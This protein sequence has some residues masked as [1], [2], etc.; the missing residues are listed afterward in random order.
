MV[1]KI[2]IVRFT[3]ENVGWGDAVMR[4]LGFII[5]ALFALIGHFWVAFD[6]RRQGWHDKIAETY[7]IRARR[8]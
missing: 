8:K 6:N 2:K 4:F 1:M 3:G 5:S 7:V